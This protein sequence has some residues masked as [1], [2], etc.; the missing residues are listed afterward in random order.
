MWQVQAWYGRR[1]G[2][3]AACSQ[4]CSLFRFTVVRGPTHRLLAQHNTGAHKRTNCLTTHSERISPDM[5]WVGYPT[6]LECIEIGRAPLCLAGAASAGCICGDHALS[7][8]IVL[9]WRY[10][11]HRATMKRSTAFWALSQAS[12]K[13][14]FLLYFSFLPMTITDESESWFIALRKLCHLPNVEVVIRG[15]GETYASVANTDFACQQYT[16]NR[17]ERLRRRRRIP[18]R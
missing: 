9:A 16:R 1:M 3:E 7:P 13:E 5:R 12:L 2:G 18:Q 15:M 4:H 8:R 11:T 14:P 6:P 17:E 10:R